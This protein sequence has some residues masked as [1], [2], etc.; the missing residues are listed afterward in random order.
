[1][2]PA[3]APMH[4]PAMNPGSVA[5]V[6]HNMRS[7]AMQPPLGRRPPVGPPPQPPGSPVNVSQF[8]RPVQQFG[9]EPPIMGH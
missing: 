7:G 8:G 3:P 2:L 4:A 1:M 5:S 9:H 6:F